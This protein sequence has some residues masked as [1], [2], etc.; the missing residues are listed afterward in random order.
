VVRHEAG[1]GAE[2][3]DVR[4]ALFHLGQLVGLNALAQFVVADL[5]FGHFGHGRRIFDACNLL[6]APLFQRLGGGGV[7]AVHV[8]DQGFRLAHVGFLK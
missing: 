1:A 8:D 5:Q 3:G 7:V 6:V 2:D 4:A